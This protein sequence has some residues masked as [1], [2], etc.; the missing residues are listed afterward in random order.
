M[1]TAKISKNPI[2][3][4]SFLPL[5]INPSSIKTRASLGCSITAEQYS[6]MASQEIMISKAQPCSGSIQ[7]SGAKNAALPLM[8]ACLLTDQ[9]VV[10]EN[11]PKI[12]DIDVMK[13]Q[14]ESYGVNVEQDGRVLQAI[15]GQTNFSPENSRGS[16][17]RGSFLVLGPL[18]ARFKEAKVHR[19]GGC[20]I[21][22]NG[23]PVNFHIDALQEMGAE[24]VQNSDYVWLKADDGLQRAQ[25]HFPRISVGATETVIM[26]ACLADGQTVITHA[27]VEPE[28]ID[29][30]KMLNE[31]GM[32]G[33]ISVYE[34]RNM[35]VINGRR[36][37]LLNGCTHTVIPGMFLV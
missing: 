20:Q 17:T 33:N 27:A 12:S 22:T 14:L 6:K 15:D 24:I 28:I 25:I 34:S 18:L 29:L 36:G 8:A 16:K 19:P 1:R 13:K 26:A 35:I 7:I 2:P 32:N 10:L 5:K 23:R 3:H 37:V 31:M 4:D 30:I 11:V 21:G 9:P